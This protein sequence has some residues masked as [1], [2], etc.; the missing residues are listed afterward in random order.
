MKKLPPKYRCFTTD[1]FRAKQ[2][3]KEGRC[4]AINYCQWQTFQHLVGRPLSLRGIFNTEDYGEIV[5]LHR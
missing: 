1:L 5:V 3:I 4:V 2:L